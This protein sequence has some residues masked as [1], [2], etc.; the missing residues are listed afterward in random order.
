VRGKGMLWGL[1]FVADRESRTPFP[2]EA[3][4]AQQV[5]LAAA[6]ERL[7]IYPRKGGGGLAG[8]H[9][10]IAPPLTISGDETEELL[11]RLDR[12]LTRSEAQLGIAA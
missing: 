8:D 7:L 12:A 2:M 5:T 10:L 4:A 3:A 11:G 9:A 1:E 6:G